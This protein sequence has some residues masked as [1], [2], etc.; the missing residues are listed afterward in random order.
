VPKRLDSAYIV[1]DAE[2]CKGCR[3]CLGVCPKNIIGMASDINQGGYLPVMV[4]EGKNREC[5]G[6]E[7]CAIMCPDTAISIFTRNTILANPVS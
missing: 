3:F 4:I 7:A 2:R 1:V 6:C 5:T